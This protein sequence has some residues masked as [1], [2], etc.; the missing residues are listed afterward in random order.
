MI[1]MGTELSNSMQTASVSSAVSQGHE[2]SIRKDEISPGADEVKLSRETRS[3]LTA[4]VL[5]TL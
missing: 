2:P 5:S 3:I 4:V 1:M